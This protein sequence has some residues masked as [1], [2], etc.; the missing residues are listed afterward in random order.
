MMR[1]AALAAITAV[2]LVLSSLVL[3]LAQNRDAAVEIP[4]LALA[5]AG[6][7]ARTFLANAPDPHVIRVGDIYYA[8]ATNGSP[9]GVGDVYNVQRYYSTDLETWTRTTSPDA[10]PVRPAWATQTGAWTW[11]P[12][13]FEASNGQYVMYFAARSVAHNRMCIGRAVSSTPNG[14]FTPTGSGPVVCQSHL[15]GSIDPYHYQ[16]PRNGNRYLY[17][18]NDGNDCSPNCLVQ[19]WGRRLDAA[20]N[21]YGSSGAILS[22]DRFWEI[23]LIENPAMTYSRVGNRFRL[24]YSG[25]WYQTSR[26][27]TG[28][29][30]CSGPLGPCTKVTTTGPWHNTTP[31][32]Y[33]PGGAA[34]FTDFEGK[35]W[36]A[37]HG[38]PAPDLVGPGGAR[39]L[40][41]EKV[42]FHSSP[43]VNTSFPFAFHKDPPHPYVDVS[44]NHWARAAIS[45]L[46]ADAAPFPASATRP[47]ATG[48][49]LDPD[50]LFRPTTSITRAQLLNWVWSLEGHPGE[51]PPPDPPPNPF[52]DSPPWIDR[53]VDWAAAE[54]HMSGY[55]DNSRPPSCGASGP[56]P[57]FR[58][59]CSI[60]RGE[61]VRL[62]WRVNGSPVGYPDHGFSD[63]PTQQLGIRRREL[64][65]GRGA[66]DR[67]SGQHLPDRHEHPPGPGRQRLVLPLRPL[68]GRMLVPAVPLGSGCDRDGPGA[69]PIGAQRAGRPEA[70][71]R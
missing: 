18:K 61:Y 30:N 46:S 14:T 27:S 67:L 36:M 11:A 63:V 15:G 56:A 64:G 13:V 58:P 55:P 9:Y 71:A 6:R 38:Y 68:T 24:F 54:G 29:A 44:S 37:Y 39:W 59:N 31:Y 49:G 53:A 20:G 25:N 17:W 66:H 47:V 10:L 40:F 22:H 45:W 60:S 23:P 12:T 69:A 57:V 26:Y 43:V 28:Y 16:D 3:P 5:S 50:E 19:L 33:G 42:D 8:Y 62:L 32:A 1:R 41:L 48:A 7:P 34:F 70:T 2:A 21:L 51:V 65:H 4:P 35:N 52:P